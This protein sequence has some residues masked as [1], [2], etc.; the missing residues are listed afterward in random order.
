[1]GMPQQFQEHYVK[2]VFL[3]KKRDTTRTNQEHITTG[4][5]STKLLSAKHDQLKKT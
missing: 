2:S 5:P 4:P 1:M 3:V